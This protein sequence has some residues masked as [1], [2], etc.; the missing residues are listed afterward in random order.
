MPKPDAVTWNAIIAGYAQN[1]DRDMALECF[2]QMHQ[3]GIKQDQFSFT[4]V[5]QSCA[6]I[7]AFEQGKSVHGHIIKYGFQYDVFVASALVDMYAK[8]G[9][10]ENAQRMFAK[11]EKRNVISW[12]AMIGGYAQNGYG[13]ETLELFEEMQLFGLEPDSITFVGVLS[14]CSHRGLVAKG[15][16]YFGCMSR[17]HGITPSV[18]HFSCVVDL[19]GRAGHLDEAK[20]FLKEIP[21][22]FRTA[23]WHALLGV[24]RAHRNVELGKQV[25]EHILDLE[26]Y[27]DAAYV[28]LSNLYAAEGRWH[29]VD[30]LRRMMKERGVKKQPGCSWIEVRKRVHTFFVGE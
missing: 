6:S 21:F 22:E 7:G 15:L 29:E 11:M 18:E 23:G 24:C 13:K 17:D 4:S 30:T 14:A 25:A 10:I 26:P 28:L 19:L 5:L 12:N 20:N 1:G 27:D 16:H 2:C 3:E 8:C 9:S